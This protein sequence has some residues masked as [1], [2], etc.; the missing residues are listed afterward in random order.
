MS[1]Y[2]IVD[3]DYV[4]RVRASFDAQSFMRTLAAELVA[5]RPGEVE[6]ALP[7]SEHVRQQHG[8]IHAGA[9]TA[10]VDNCCGFASQTL[11]APNREIL[12]VEFKVNFMS[13]A[14][15]PR[16]LAYGRVKRAGKQ[17]F[18]VEGDVFGLEAD[19]ARKPVASM[20]TTMI[21]VDL[22]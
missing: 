9:L 20:L 13:P 21:A 5:V 4:A 6:I 8:F 22:G 15:A 14:R 2:K 17:L 16:F 7:N 11:L 19:G 3:P 10:I 18:V 1:A 12:T